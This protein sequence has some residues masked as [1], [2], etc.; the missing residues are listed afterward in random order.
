MK[1]ELSRLIPLKPTENVELLFVRCCLYEISQTHRGPRKMPWQG[2][3][4]R[5]LI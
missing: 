4:L 2:A 3:C 1:A 5:P